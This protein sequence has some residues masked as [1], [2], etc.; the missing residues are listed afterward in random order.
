MKAKTIKTFLLLACLSAYL[1]SC[2]E[3][4][5]NVC[6]SSD[7]ISDLPWLSA[8]QDSIQ[9]QGWSGFINSYNYRG[10]QVIFINPNPTGAE[11][12]N[13]CTARDCNGNVLCQW[14]G[15]TLQVTCPNFWNEASN[16]QEL[17][18]N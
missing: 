1:Y 9:D 12:D 2:D 18:S 6:N 4:D 14:G 8:I 3:V 7:P 17:W 11:V 15:P 13:L 16:T 10:E 5:S